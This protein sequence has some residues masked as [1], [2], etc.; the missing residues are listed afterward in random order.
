MSDDYSANIHTDGSV[1]VGGSA[2]G[3]IETVDDRDWFAVDFVAGKT[4]RISLE[5]AETNQ[6]TLD[7]PYLRG[8]FRANGGDQ[9]DNLIPGTGDDDSGRGLDAE[10]LYVATETATYYVAAGAAGSST[11]TYKL[12]VE[13]L[14]D[15]FRHD[16]ATTGT[17]AVGESVAGDIQFAGD[18][19]WFAVELEAGKTYR[20][21]L[22]GSPT[23]EGT[24]RDPYLRGIH[25]ANGDLVAYTT[26]DDGGDGFNSRV[27]FVAP[28]TATYY[29]AAG[30][31]R[32]STGTYKLSVEELVDE[33]AEELTEELRDDTATTGTVAV[34]ESVTGNIQ[35]A[36]DRDWFAVE[37]E[38][39]KAYRIDLEGLPTDEGTLRD[40]YLRGIHDANGDIIAYTINDDGGDGFNSRVTFVA[41]E[42]ATYYVA[43][44]G[45]TSYWG[46][47]TGSYWG[48]GTY[49]LSVTVIEDDFRHDTATTGTVA[50]GESVAGDI[51]FA[52]DRDWF[53]VE[54]EAGK[55]YRIDLEGSP[56][57]EGTLSDPYLRGIHDANGDLIAYTTNDD[58]GD[59]Y[60]SRVTFVAPE[61]ATYYVAAGAVRS[62]TGTY[63]LSL[64]VDEVA[65]DFRHDTATTGT[66]AVGE[67]VAGDIQFAGDHDW[68]AVELEAGKTYRIDLEGSPTGEGT[69]S[70]PYLRGIHD[71]NGDL[72]AN[73]IDDDSGDGANSR[74][75]FVAPDTAT[76]YIVAG[77]YDRYLGASTGTYKLS[78]EEIPDDFRDDTATTGT[79]AVGESV[80]GD[81]Q[82]AGDRDWF[83]VE[84]EA[85]KTYRI[86][87][88]GSPTGE[89]TLSDPYLGGIHD[90]NGDRIANTIDDDSGDG[91]NSRV[92]FV[93]P[94]TATYYVAASGYW[95]TPTGTYKL[96]VSA[97]DELAGELRDDTATTGTV[98]VGESVT[99]DIQ[100]A[101]DRDWFAVELEAGKAYR[102]DLEGS[103]TGEGTLRDP[104][105]RGIHDANGDIIAHT[106]NDDG[107]D[108]FNSRVTFVAP[109][110]A[111][112]Y[113]AAGGYTSYWAA[114][115]T[116]KL[117]VTVIEDDFSAGTDT[118][119][120][121]TVGGST[122]GELEYDGDRDWFAVS[123]EADAIYRIDVK[124]D[125]GAD[126]GGTLHNPSFR[127]HDASGSAIVLAADDNSGVGLNARLS[128]FAPDAGGTYYI[129]VDDPGGLGTYTV[130]VEEV[131]YSL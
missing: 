101:G 2:T 89:G 114:T 70:D 110:T 94:E 123:L 60:N 39:G 128:A 14:A 121:V 20:I 69:L 68:F 7:D 38:A 9:D 109:E 52:G 107:G 106:T 50:V 108:G 31:F 126:Y 34:G 3:E 46:G 129:A 22:E 81:I 49:K 6:G 91:A 55:A 53:A 79:V 73:T 21:D 26:D 125:T 35:F 66:V 37:L 112:Y 17:V 19:D 83:A 64:S 76:Y 103:H 99:G 13:E 15:D 65:D 4:Y 12:S 36:G 92:T 71:A 24:L 131:T 67:S 41:P 72:I 56:T 11:G 122:T 47:Y 113:V 80:A 124:G 120:S 27:T 58:A 82:F 10:V 18:R 48:T 88:E 86:D 8:I 96:S 51:Q 111:T 63:K 5:G 104:Y 116:Y 61:T 100:F 30:A 117:S 74:V 33:L 45:Y 57:G 62:F 42:T 105:L 95:E 84:L 59:G 44:G 28:E 29:V 78:V 40:P 85:G 130:A 93:A 115:G 16:T 98:A 23:G 1:A 127:M 119:G 77:S 87:L 54:L 118:E 25:D 32:F 90:A 97:V 102:I 75:M 43:A